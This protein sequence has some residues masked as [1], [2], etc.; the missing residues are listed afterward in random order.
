M[1]DLRHQVPR[2]NGKVWIMS[3]W[4]EELDKEKDL[5]EKRKRDTTNE[6]S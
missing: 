5:I 6:L 2:E 1:S 3:Q 4:Q